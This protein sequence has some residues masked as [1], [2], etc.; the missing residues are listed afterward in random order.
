MTKDI[1]INPSTKVG[2]LLDAYPELEDELIRIAPAF[3][4]LKN[5]LL[6]KTVGKAATMKH[7][8]SVGDIPLNELINKLRTAVGQPPSRDSYDDEDYFSA[9]PD[10]FSI[11]KI[12]ISMDESKIEDKDTW[13]LTLVLREAKKIEKGE[14]IELITSFLPAPGIDRMRSLGYSV[15][16]TKSKNGMFKTYFLKKS[17]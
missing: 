9:K 6:R 7:I 14:I 8:S 3:K 5:P 11:D 17:S 4:K 16:A 1:D 15:W 2:D 13:T 10:W 12:K